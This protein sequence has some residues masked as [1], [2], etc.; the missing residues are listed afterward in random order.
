MREVPAVVGADE[1]AGPAGG[2]AEA[3]EEQVLRGGQRF[4]GRRDAPAPRDRGEGI[5]HVTEDDLLRARRC[6]EDLEGEGSAAGEERHLAPN[7]VPG[8]N[9]IGIEIE[10]E[11]E[12]QLQSYVE[13]MLFVCLSLIGFGS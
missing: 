7:W 10:L 4:R 8:L 1:R 2:D 5:R 11:L 13:I 6:R 3:G 9:A 12:L